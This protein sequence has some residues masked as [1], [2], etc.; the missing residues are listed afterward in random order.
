MKIW[1]LPIEPFEERYTAQWYRWWPE[2][3]RALGHTVE[4]IDGE[5]VSERRGGE[6]LDPL[7]TWIWKGSQVAVLARRWPEMQPEDWLLNLDGWGPGSTAAAYMRATTGKGPRLAW[8]MH[9]GSYDPQDFLARSGCRYWALDLERGWIKAADRLLVGSRFHLHLIREHLGINVTLPQACVCGVPIKREALLAASGG[10]TPWEDRPRLVLF[11]HR[12]APEKAPEEFARIQEI[13]RA[14]YPESHRWTI[15]QRTRDVSRSKQDYYRLLAQARCV[16]STARQE[17]FG[18]AMQ[19]G[20]A[21]GAWAVAPRRCSYPE[22]IRPGTG[23]LYDSLEEAAHLVERALGQTASPVWDGWHEKA[24]E[25]AVASL[26][27]GEG[28]KDV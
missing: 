27:E 19:E 4:V 13:H 6:F 28:G 25:R 16:V 18:I 7:Q 22:V 1:C 15:W 8:F 3:I 21:L 2:E 20:I 11:P 17:T 10:V 9:A 5:A 26:V 24:I 14:I 12:L 23:W